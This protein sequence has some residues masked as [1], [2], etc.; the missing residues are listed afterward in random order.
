MSRRAF[1]G[2]AVSPALRA[3]RRSS[4]L[5]RR[6]PAVVMA[7]KMVAA[8]STMARTPFR[9]ECR[10]LP[11]QS[12]AARAASDVIDCC[13]EADD[14]AKLGDFV[15]GLVPCLEGAAVF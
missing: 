13:C 4:S 1:P 7:G 6:G 9:I 12:E 8:P 10:M 3:A 5:S 15:G 2:T 11:P 14:K